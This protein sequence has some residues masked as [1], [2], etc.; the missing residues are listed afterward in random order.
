MHDFKD[1]LGRFATKINMGVIDVGGAEDIKAAFDKFAD[2]FVK[3]CINVIDKIDTM[4]ISDQAKSRMKKAALCGWLSI[5]YVDMDVIKGAAST[6]S[7]DE[8]DTTLSKPGATKKDVFDAFGK[9]T[10]NIDAKLAPVFEK[11]KEVAPSDRY[12]S[13][14]LLILALAHSR[15]GLFDK[16]ANFFDK[17]DV[18]DP[19]NNYQKIDGIGYP[20]AKFF[21]LFST[22][23][24][25]DVAA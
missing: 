4:D 7:L 3:M 25:N 24:N 2:D 17:P 23:K 16:I 12:M 11:V 14:N 19:A 8:L 10:A 5:K 20:A 13:E 22:L 6:I 9:V 1:A 21:M 18:R 15:E